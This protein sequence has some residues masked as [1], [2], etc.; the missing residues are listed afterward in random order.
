MKQCQGNNAGK[1]RRCE[2]L[3]DQSRLQAE[4]SLPPNPHV[5]DGDMACHQR[6]TLPRTHSHQGVKA[7]YQP[8]KGKAKAKHK[9]RTAL[10]EHSGITGISMQ[11]SFT[12]QSMF[13]WPHIQVSNS[14]EPNRTAHIG[15]ISIMKTCQN[16]ET[17][18]LVTLRCIN[19]LHKYL[20]LVL[21]WK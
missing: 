1:P 16:Q 18:L 20:I 4:P 15:W 5:A 21:G 10:L 2:S 3:Q 7:L 17:A 8:G 11:N 19:T 9:Q 12:K 6:S 13:S 14:A